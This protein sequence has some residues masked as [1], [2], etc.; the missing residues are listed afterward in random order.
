MGRINGFDAVHKLL[1]PCSF[2]KGCDKIHCRHRLVGISKNA[3]ALV[4]DIVSGKAHPPPEG[5]SRSPVPKPPC[6]AFMCVLDL[7][8]RK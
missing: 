4:D 7:E 8:V 5:C 2:A 1:Q 3:R 6:F